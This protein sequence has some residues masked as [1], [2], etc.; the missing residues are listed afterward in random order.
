MKNSLFCPSRR[1]ALFRRYFSL[2]SQDLMRL[3]KSTVLSTLFIMSHESH[4]MHKV[5]QMLV[6]TKKKRM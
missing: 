6:N 4:L 5:L 2:H 3:R 1:L